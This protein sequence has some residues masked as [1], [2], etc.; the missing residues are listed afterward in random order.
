MDIYFVEENI[1]SIYSLRNG[2]L[3]EVYSYNTPKQNESHHAFQTSPTI[4]N[5]LMSLIY[6]DG[7]KSPSDEV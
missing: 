7:V 4:G 5:V 2:F 1:Q 3:Y 6:S